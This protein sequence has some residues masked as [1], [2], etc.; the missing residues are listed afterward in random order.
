MQTFS[1]NTLQL[2]C[3]NSKSLGLRVPQ[4]L[5]PETVKGRTKMGEKI[6]EQLRIWVAEK[7]PK[8]IQGNFDRNRTEITGAPSKDDNTTAANS[9]DMTSVEAI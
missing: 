6:A 3:K 1:E 9:Q 8:T 2:S 7:E 5:D 4:C